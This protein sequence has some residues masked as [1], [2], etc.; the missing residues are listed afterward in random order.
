MQLL[1]RLSY[2][3]SHNYATTWKPASAQR[4]QSADQSADQFSIIYK[5]LFIWI[6]AMK[7]FLM[8]STRRASFLLVLL[9]LNAFIY[10]SKA[11]SQTVQPKTSPSQPANAQEQ[12]DSPLAGKIRK[13]AE[14]YVDGEVINSAVIGV[15]DGDAEFVL[16]VG[17]LSKTDTAAPNRDT[18]FEIGS[19]SKVFTGSLVGRCD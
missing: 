17:Q 1:S 9:L 18:V 13:L 2:G 14:A 10:G 11:Y 19:V 16:G 6:N 8:L 5:R 3:V 7:V 4:H 12:A 15:I